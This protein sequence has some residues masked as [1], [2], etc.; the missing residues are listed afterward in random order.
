[1]NKCKHIYKGV[2]L[3][4]VMSPRSADVYD[5]AVSTGFYQMPMATLV[6]E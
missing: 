4:D 1:M 2:E 5:K 6:L 3:D